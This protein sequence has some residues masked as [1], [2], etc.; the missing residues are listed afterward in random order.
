METNCPITDRKLILHACSMPSWQRRQR[1][2]AKAKATKGKLPKPQSSLAPHPSCNEADP[3]GAGGLCCTL[4]AAACADSG[5]IAGRGKKRKKLVTAWSRHLQNLRVLGSAM[6]AV[7]APQ[8]HLGWAGL[9][10]T[11]PDMDMVMALSS[12]GIKKQASRC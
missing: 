11:C 5:H 8:V 3:V 4:K 9:G 10:Q 7:F 12:Q 1:E 2:E 6:Q